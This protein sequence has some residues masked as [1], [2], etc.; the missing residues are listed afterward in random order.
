MSVS[1]HYLSIIFAL[2]KGAVRNPDNRPTASN[3]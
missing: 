3:R 1:R 2:F